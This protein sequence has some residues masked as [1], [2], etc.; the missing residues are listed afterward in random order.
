MKTIIIFLSALYLI[1][2]CSTKETIQTITVQRDTTF[3]PEVVHDS[4]FIYD[5]SL[6]QWFDNAVELYRAEID[7][8]KRLQGDTTSMMDFG[9]EFAKPF[10]HTWKALKVTQKGDSIF[11]TFRL[12]KSN[13]TF[14]FREVSAPIKIKVNDTQT[15]ITKEKEL[16]WIEQAWIDFKDFILIGMIFLLIAILVWQRLKGIIRLG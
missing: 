1:G 11:V 3:Q 10:K 5:E 4:V 13:G 16:S 7:S 2:C 14:I 12:E 8:L 9:T 6:Q 15:I